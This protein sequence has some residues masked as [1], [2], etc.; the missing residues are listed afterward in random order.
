MTI[1]REGDCL[2]CGAPAP[3]AGVLKHAWDCHRRP[4]PPRVL[5]PEE[6]QREREAFA[7]ALHRCCEVWARRTQTRRAA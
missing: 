7:A 1:G 5:T 6:A 3:V 4:W 2:R